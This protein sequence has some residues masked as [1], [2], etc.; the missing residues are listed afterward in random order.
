MHTHDIHTL[1][2]ELACTYKTLLHNK[3]L[4]SHVSTRHYYKIKWDVNLNT[5]AGD[6]P[7]TWHLAE[8]RERHLYYVCMIVGSVIC[9]FSGFVISS[10]CD[11]ELTATYFGLGSFLPILML[12][13][14]FVFLN[15]YFIKLD[16]VHFSLISTKFA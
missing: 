16:F 1:T 11:S 5:S 14:E 12:C 3:L 4:N 6:S 10:L 13:G 15:I 7:L 2:V 9:L 8:S